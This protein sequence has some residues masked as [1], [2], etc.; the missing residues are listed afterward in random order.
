MDYNLF[1]NLFQGREGV[2]AKQ[3][4]SGEAYSPVRPDRQIE[5]NDIIQHIQ[6]TETYGIYP[7]R[8][9]NM[10]KLVCFDIDL[11]KDYAELNISIKEH[12]EK[13]IDI[14]AYVL[15]KQV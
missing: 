8:H 14:L 11:P 15:F 3:W 1:L 4:P 13:P 2:F 6:G 12:S 5:I 7:I 10:V 9:G